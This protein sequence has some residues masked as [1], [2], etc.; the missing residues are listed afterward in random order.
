M[1]KYIVEIV[2]GGWI[3]VVWLLGLAIGYV[4]GGAH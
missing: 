3:I 1:S 2:L 4:I